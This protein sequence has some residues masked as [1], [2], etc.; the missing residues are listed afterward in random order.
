MMIKIN[1][2]T[3]PGKG[4]GGW[5]WRLALTLP[6]WWT[7]VGQCQGGGLR[8]FQPSPV[9]AGQSKECQPVANSQQLHFSDHF[10]SVQTEQAS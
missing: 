7:M 4:R 9:G 1:F 6:E 2:L 5:A 3:T 10:N 8:Q